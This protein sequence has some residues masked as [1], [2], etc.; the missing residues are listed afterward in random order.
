MSFINAMQLSSY[1]LRDRHS[2][3]ASSVWTFVLFGFNGMEMQMHVCSMV[4][5]LGFC[6]YCYQ[7]LAVPVI[8]CICCKQN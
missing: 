2:D 1:L 7:F 6:H 4:G 3:R 5:S 8:C